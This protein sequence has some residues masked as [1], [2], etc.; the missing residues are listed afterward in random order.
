M[1]ETITTIDILNRLARKVQDVK[2]AIETKDM[3][4]LREECTCS[5]ICGDEN[6]LFDVPVLDKN[7]SFKYKGF[8]C[9]LSS[10][11]AVIKLN[12]LIGNMDREAVR[13]K[14][15]N[16][17]FTDR[18]VCWLW[19]TKD[20]DGHTLDEYLERNPKESEDDN[21]WAPE[22]YLVPKAWAWG[23]DPDLKPGETVEK[24][25]L[26]GIDEFLKENPNI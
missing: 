6:I 22:V 20:S 16:G 3:N 19:G 24:I 23:A 9:E 13:D 17:I 2:N 18:Y 11:N 8:D 1:T 15:P 10:C 25:I 21:C 12:Q 4:K 14:F 26:I 5:L 7:L